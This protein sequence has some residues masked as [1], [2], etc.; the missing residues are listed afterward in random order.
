MTNINAF[1]NHFANKS[2]LPQIQEKKQK[3]EKQEVKE[4]LQNPED[5]LAKYPLR[6]FGYANEIGAALSAMPGWGKTAEALL[7]VPALMYLGADIFD[8]YS[9][10]KEGN[11]S[12]P[13]VDKAVEQATFQALASVI[14]PT[15]A[16]KM[17]QKIAGHAAKYDGSKL[18]ASA[19]EELYRK[20]LDD[21]DKG[22]FAKSDY[23][24]TAPDG[25]QTVRKGFD[26][27]M[28]KILTEDYEK[29]L[30]DTAHDLKTEGIW[31]KVKRFFAHTSRPVSS[32][33]SERSNVTEFLKNKA[34]EIFE[35]QNQLETITE[36]GLEKLKPDILK[37]YKKASK[38]IDT[39][40]QELI[41]ENPSFVLKKI[42]NSYNPQMKQFEAEIIKKY[43]GD[44][45]KVL[46]KDNKACSQM[47]K[48]LMQN[49]ESKKTILEH[50]KKVK[51]ARDALRPIL[52]AK[53]MRL[54]WLKTAGGFAALAC[55]A[56][57]IDHFVHKY[58]IQKA[59][60]PALENVEKFNKNFKKSKET[61]KA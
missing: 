33:T 15:A 20:L 37:K 11:Y 26:R 31:S 27:M 40:V 21:F 32:A 18:T 24:K 50:T 44:S 23:T 59:V 1:F 3:T 38:N 46:L 10:G 34:K 47:L 54:G 61:S 58:I 52:K 60:A 25:T 35:L 42:L 22:R 13:A 55:L 48:E 2:T 7:W 19:Q 17:G 5:P 4:L 12:K 53:E 16:V 8:K 57:P 41:T 29:L 30:N 14:L 9:R 28:N 43:S 45:L 56:I 39:K 49:P 51:I 6:G 36:E